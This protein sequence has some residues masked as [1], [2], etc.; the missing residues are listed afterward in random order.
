[1]RIP[2]L[3]QAA[4]TKLAIIHLDDDAEATR[5]AIY[6]QNTMQG[7]VQCILRTCVFARSLC[8]CVHIRSELTGHPMHSIRVSVY[9]ILLGL[10]VHSYLECLPPPSPLAVH[11][12]IVRVRS[13]AWAASL[14][15][16][17]IIAVHG[18]SAYHQHLEH[19]SLDASPSAQTPSD[20]SENTSL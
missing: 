19:L 5:L 20:S 13:T 9:C 3:A 12:V 4:S 7:T 17:G 6:L 1:M 15:Q 11:T 16:H 10:H 8:S 14:A 18:A 2:H